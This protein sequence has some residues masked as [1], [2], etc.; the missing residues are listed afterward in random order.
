V[1]GAVA[2]GEA[3][4]GV[5]CEDP[6]CAPLT[7]PENGRDGVVTFNA[8]ANYGSHGNVGSSPPYVYLTAHE[9]GHMLD[10][11]HSYTGTGQG[12]WGDQYDDPLDV[13]SQPPTAGCS[14]G[15]FSTVPQRTLAINRYAAGWIDP[16]LVAVHDGGAA[17]YVLGAEGSGHTELLVIRS[18]DGAAYTTLEARVG[19]HAGDLDQALPVAGVAVT[20]VDQRP[21][22]ECYLVQAL[23]LPRCTG[24]DRRTQPW[25]PN[26]S[27][28]TSFTSVLTNGAHLDLGGV[29]VTVTGTNPF[30]VA[31]SGTAAPF[32]A[33]RPC[34][35]PQPNGSVAC[36]APALQDR[37][38]AADNLGTGRPAPARPPVDRLRTTIAAAG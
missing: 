2:Y 34:P 23:G 26:G 13:M 33:I 11:P 7:Y 24:L 20:R 16:A 9:E 17:N 5:T 12:C 28:P 19:G 29:T 14:G 35:V 27:Q 22:P 31:V 38:T 37:V 18:G 21:D 10:W 4:P 32:A 15:S 8:L 30:T 3:T 25:G 1:Q 36:P 6:A